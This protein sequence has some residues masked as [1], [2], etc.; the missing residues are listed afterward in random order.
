MMPA[1]VL[2]S[3]SSC[4]TQ[5]V[6]TIA[7]GIMRPAKTKKLMNGVALSVLRCMTKPAIAD[8]TTRITIDKTVINVLL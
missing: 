4:S 5:M 6:G 8:M 1:N 2:N 3:A 7:G